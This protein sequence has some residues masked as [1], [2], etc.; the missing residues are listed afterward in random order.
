MKLTITT[1]FYYILLL[2]LSLILVLGSVACSSNETQQAQ[3][4]VRDS[5]GIK[6]IENR[7]PLWHKEKN[8]YIPVEPILSLVDDAFFRIIGAVRFEDGR[9]VVANSGSGELRFYDQKGNFKKVIGRPGKGPGEFSRLSSIHKF[10]NDSLIAF[11]ASLYRVT[12]F[13]NHGI[14]MEDFN[15]ERD[16][17]HSFSDVKV[18]SDGTLFIS[19]IW[20][21]RLERGDKSNGIKRHPAPYYRYSP[22]GMLIDTVAI[23]PGK[24]IFMSV[25]KEIFSFSF[26]LPYSH[27]PVSAVYQN[28]AYIGTSD[29]FDI[30]VYTPTGKLNRIIQLVGVVDLHLSK[31]EIEADKNVTIGYFD[32]PDIKKRQAKL[33]SNMPDSKS[34]PAYS[35]MIIDNAGNLWIGEH[36]PNRKNSIVWW[37]F[38]QDGQYL[39]EIKIHNNILVYE[40][41]NDYIL[42]KKLDKDGFES[43]WVYGLIKP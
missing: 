3:N 15:L 30:H 43:I 28:K 39:F 8:W 26:N 32:D 22:L 21:S 16:I 13:D 42:G 12:I 35:S 6:I 11:D 23:L 27:S 9:V 40:I 5:L 10:S 7:E 2:S 38:N 24:E 20:S 33:L 34:K 19:T 4:T 1:I 37:V 18:F 29:R 14:F 17:K 31:E 41:G 25:E 36:L